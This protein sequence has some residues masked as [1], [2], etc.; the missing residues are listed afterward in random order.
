MM[1]CL[2]N[3]NSSELNIILYD[4]NLER[5]FNGQNTQIKNKSVRI[6]IN[7]LNL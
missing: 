5:N 7:F 1:D 2:K 4:D 3:L 6:L